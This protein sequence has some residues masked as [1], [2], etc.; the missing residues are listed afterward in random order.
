M[1]FK[2]ILLAAAIAIAV[3]PGVLALR[4]AIDYE[5]DE[6]SPPAWDAEESSSVS[7]SAPRQELDRPNKPIMNRPIFKLMQQQQQPMMPGADFHQPQVGFQVVNR[8]VQINR[9]RKL[10]LETNPD[11]K[12]PCEWTIGQAFA[13]AS[14]SNGFAYVTEGSDLAKAIDPAHFGQ[15]SSVKKDGDYLL[16]QFEKGGAITIPVGSTLKD[17]VN[18][19][20]HNEGLHLGK[21]VIHSQG[22]QAIS[23]VTQLNTVNDDNPFA[24]TITTKAAQNE[25]TLVF[26]DDTKLMKWP[27]A[28]LSDFWTIR[29]Q[30]NA[31][32]D[33]QLAKTGFKRNLETFSPFFAPEYI[34]ANVAFPFGVRNNYWPALKKILGVI[35]EQSQESDSIVSHKAG[36]ASVRLEL[37]ENQSD[38][39]GEFMWGFK[40]ETD[41]AFLFRMV[42]DSN[43]D[44][45]TS[46]FRF[47]IS[48]TSFKRLPTS[49]STDNE[50]KAINADEQEI[51]DTGLRKVAINEDKFLYFNARYGVSATYAGRSEQPAAMSVKAAYERQIE[52][53]VKDMAENLD[54]N[55][56]RSIVQKIM[57]TAI[58]KMGDISALVQEAQKN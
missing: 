18:V 55:A 28:Q 57:A 51:V 41:N 31:D 12:Q 1:I 26:I 35:E 34:W 53:K 8:N 52:D 24:M 36:T 43:A 13:A 44:T 38:R 7:I 48:D 46:R 32:R 15:M 33:M 5:A 54:R 30:P 4:C 3:M 16:A 21:T 56:V 22:V 37:L 2:K 49:V 40:G 25:F 47:E 42:F 17:T 14:I 27:I 9:R 20:F 50:N 19:R 10:L 6:L 58:F 39:D 23:D 11:E 29:G 45:A